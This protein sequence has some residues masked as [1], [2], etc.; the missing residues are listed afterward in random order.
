VNRAKAALAAAVAAC[1]AVALGGQ[2]AKPGRWERAMQAFERSDANNPPPKREIVFIGSSSIVHWNLPKYFPGLKATNRGFGGSVIADSVQ[3]AHRI[4][5]PLEPRIVVLY[6]GDNDIARGMSP[7]QVFADFKAFVKKVHERLP[8]TKIV[9]VCIK[10]SIARW[11]LWDKMRAANKLI[12]DYAKGHQRLVYLDIATPML[13][14]DGKP[15]PELLARDGLHLSPAGY[16]LWSK[17]LAP[18][19]K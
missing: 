10:P 8:A 3:Y 11:K 1:C 6:A 5:L 13:G 2:A 12:E 15:R 18:H 14:D 9:F 4:L 7:Q 19:L 17:L 16:E